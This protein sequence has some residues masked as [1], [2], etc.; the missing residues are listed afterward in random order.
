MNLEMG[1]IL[2][3]AV[4]YSYFDDDDDHHRHV[5]GVRLLLWIAANNGPHASDT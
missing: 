5:D 2:L 1:I 4:N 3:T